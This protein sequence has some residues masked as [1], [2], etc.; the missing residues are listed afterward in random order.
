[1]MREEI[2]KAIGE[3]VEDLI[4]SGIKTSFSEKELKELGV[5]IPQVDINAHDIQTIREKIKLS[6]SVFAKLLNVSLS[7]VR[8]WEQGTRKPSGSTQVLL[9][10]LQTQPKILNY[11]LRRT[12]RRK[13]HYKSREKV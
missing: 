12:G 5:K 3:T 6:Q 7:S 8:Q 1:M 13:K 10:L 9:E 2:K 11:R 4:A